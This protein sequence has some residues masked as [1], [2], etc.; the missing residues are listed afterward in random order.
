MYILIDAFKKHE[1]LMGTEQAVSF[2][3]ILKVAEYVKLD[4]K[5]L[6]EILNIS[7]VDYCFLKLTDKSNNDSQRR[8]QLFREQNGLLENKDGYLIK[9]KF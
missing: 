5:R 2:D 8:F 4:Y 9:I 7:N 1:I 3:E 6:Y